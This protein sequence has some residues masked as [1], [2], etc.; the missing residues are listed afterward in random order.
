MSDY[1]DLFDRAALDPDPAFTAALED[2]LTGAAAVAEAPARPSDRRRRW[3]AVIVLAAA[4]AIAAVAI[5]LTANDDSDL[6]TVPGTEPT[7]TAVAGPPS[8]VTLPET[9]VAPATTAA[10]PATTVPPAPTSIVVAV[11]A[12]FAPA[13]VTF[14][15][16]THGWLL[17]GACGQP[18]CPTVSLATTDDRGQA[19]HAVGAPPV[20]FGDPDSGGY[21]SV[22]FANE[23]DGYVFGGDL[24]VTHDGA[25]SWQ[26]V[27]LPGEGD[28][29]EVVAL[30]TS[31]G[32][33]YAVFTTDDGFRVASS[34]AASD[35]WQLDPLV[36][37]YGGGPVPTIQL[38]L[39]GTAGWLIENDRVVVAGARLADGAWSEWTPPCVDG[40][41]PAMLT[42][43]DA[44][45]LDAV[46]TEGV[47]G[48]PSTPATRL[49]RS[50]DG[51]A[52]FTASP[53]VLP[54]P[55]GS[56][57]AAS[58]P[59]PETLVVA[60]ADEG[61]TPVLYATFDSGQT[62]ELAWTGPGAALW[63]DLG[64]TTLQQGVVVLGHDGGT[65]D[66]LMTFDGGH[67]WSATSLTG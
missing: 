41:G 51:G 25:G 15:S 1:R 65:A 14:V 63:N 62:W 16:P 6:T 37:P 49:Y 26:Q 44:S 21:R 43:S 45:H 64:F 20:G 53:N 3:A 66:L 56:V 9:T 36:I 8:S 29:T 24:W 59:G 58:S 57:A 18:S 17:G 13:S 12:G 47:W 35:D 2:R 40:G 23:R 28:G 39:H 30:E 22:R 10:P 7:T 27:T 67:T 42:A 61:G 5:F 19:W 38:V 48:G 46:C 34:P 32:T 4:A 11:P 54:V 33:T 52:T 60:A 31:G 55:T 50:S